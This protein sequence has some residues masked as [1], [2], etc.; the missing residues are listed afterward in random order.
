MATEQ[1]IPTSSPTASKEP[2]SMLEMEIIGC[3][4]FLNFLHKCRSKL[5]HAHRKEKRE[6]IPKFADLVKAIDKESKA[7]V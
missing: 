6:G 4:S 5:K 7:R 1:K 3:L 2:N